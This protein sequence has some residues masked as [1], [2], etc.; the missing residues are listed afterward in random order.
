MGVEILKIFLNPILYLVVA[1]VIVTLLWI[2]KLFVFKKFAALEFLGII[3]SVIILIMI[4]TDHIAVQIISAVIYVAFAGYTIYSFIETYHIYTTYDKEIN[5]FLKNNEFDFFVQTDSKDKIINFSNKLLNITKMT[6]RDII[7]VHCWKLLIDYLKINKINKKELSLNTTASFLKEFKDANS[8]HV[9]YQFEFE[10][11]KL[12][13]LVKE[14]DDQTKDLATV[15]YTGLI[16]PVYYNKKL[17]GRNIYFYQ[18][19]MQVLHD[20]RLALKNATIDLQTSYNF[21]YIMMSL[22]DYVGMYFDPNT[23]TYVATE[24]F[25]KFTNTHQREYTFN[26]FMD[27][28]HPDDVEPYIEQASTI[29]SVSVTKIKY[30][31]LINE[32]YYY[33]M[34]DSININK[35]A[36]LV[37]V[38]RIINKTSDG[39]KHDTPLSTHE[40]ETLIDKLSVSDI[41]GVISKTENILNVIVGNDE[42]KN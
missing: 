20:L 28:M 21:N 5:N 13:E 27:L 4:P 25:M 37:S 30:R 6:K 29:N 24:A 18:D 8:K 10:M 26:Q 9:I 17:I 33:V 39:F 35:D 34:E 7:G 32:D 16:Q 14:K 19:R 41:S 12:D 1:F 22:M 23:R 3:L 31:L 2:V 15:R 11:P 40:A 38:I 42:E 36:D